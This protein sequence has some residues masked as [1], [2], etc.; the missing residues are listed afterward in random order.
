VIPHVLTETIWEKIMRFSPAAIALSLSFA[1]LSS[2][3]TG[4]PADDVINPLSISFV[5]KGDA[6]SKLKQYNEAVDFYE[7][8]LAIDPRNRAAY[9]AMARVQ[10]SKNLNGKAI[11]FYG[12]ALELEPNDQVALAEQGQTMLLKGALSQAKLN[13][14]RLQMLC[15]SQCE[16][17]ISLAAAIKSA[18]EKPV[19]QA[20][21]VEIKPVATT[22]Q[23][24]TQP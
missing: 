23:K 6:A 11:R 8:A 2:A 1:V 18:G 17:V 14:A 24:P 16:S 7:S 20:S 5:Q 10:R 9:I 12:E 3:S 22:E 4:K 15:K 19:I 21:A 13:L